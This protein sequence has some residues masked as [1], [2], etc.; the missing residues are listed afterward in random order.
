M[1]DR[2]KVQYK[3][4]SCAHHVWKKTGEFQEPGHRIKIFLKC[5]H[6][7]KIKIAW[8]DEKQ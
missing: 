7:P 1:H 8:K 3:S 2:P 5:I 4:L 6:C